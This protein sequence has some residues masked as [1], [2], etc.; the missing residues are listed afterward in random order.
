MV[1][2]PDNAAEPMM[3]KASRVLCPTHLNQLS[4]WLHYPEKQQQPK[5]PDSFVE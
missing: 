3:P 1:V 2:A 4:Q 5:R